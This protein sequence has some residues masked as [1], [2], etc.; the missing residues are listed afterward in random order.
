MDDLYRETSADPEKKFEGTIGRTAKESKP[1]KPAIIYPPEGAPN[2][3]IVL[4]DDVGFGA[5]DVF[6][7][8]VPM[9]ALRQVADEGLRYNQFHTCALCSPT[10]AAVLTGR[11][12][13]SAHFGA[14][15][16][17]AIGY[18]ATTASS[19]RARPPSRRCSRATATTPPGSARTTSPHVGDQPGGTLRPL[20]DR[21]G[22]RALLRL[23]GRRIVAVGAFAAGPDHAI[24]PHLEKENYHLSED[25][26]DKAISWIA[27]RRP[28]P[29]TSPSSS[30]SRR[31]R[32]TARITRRRSGSRSSRAS[33]TR[34]G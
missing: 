20:A 13:H 26:A 34:A 3:V 21:P 18:P 2:V 23:H 17:I 5:S 25:L 12:H 29:R 1:D 10:R 24:N 19:P 6:G 7:G 30:T 16:E 14:I 22:V 11:N 33:S 15:S 9:P 4:L 27:T 8:P 31:G 28:P 32:H